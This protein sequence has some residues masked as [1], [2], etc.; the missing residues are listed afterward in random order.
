[1]GIVRARPISASALVRHLAERFEAER[2]RRRRA[3]AQH[4]LRVAIDAAP[5]ARPELLAD[6]VATVLGELGVPA[7]RVSAQQFLRPASLRLERGREDPDA[8]Y[9]DWQDRAALLREVLV[10]LGPQGSGR[11]LPSLWDAARDRS[12]RAA[13]VTAPPAAVLL[14][15]GTFLL[16]RE[17]PWDDSVH[18]ALTE[19]ALRRRTPAPDQWTLPAFQRYERNVMPAAVAGVVVRVDDPRHPA[20]VERDS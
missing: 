18:L 2:Q 16:G 15:D 3:G 1:M 14:L 11:Y 20:L 8:F 4:A 9:E 19:A 12:T 5:T 10:P 6:A 17:L 7:V 13:Y